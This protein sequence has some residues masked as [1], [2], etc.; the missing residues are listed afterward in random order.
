M[1]TGRA[2]HTAL[3]KPLSDEHRKILKSVE[4]D[5]VRDMDADEIL[6]R[7][8]AENVFNPTEEERIKVKTIRSEKNGQ[9][10][11]ILPTKG[12][13]AYQ[14]FKEALL[15]VH[16]PLRNIIMERENMELGSNANSGQAD[17]TTQAPDSTENEI[18]RKEVVTFQRCMSIQ[19]D[20][21]TC[22]KELGG[23]LQI[24][25][26][27]LHNIK[28]DNGCARDRGLAVLQSWR[29]REGNDATVGCLFDAFVRIGKKRTAEN[30]FAKR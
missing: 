29:D 6:L 25:E 2:S 14:I 13:K 22:W 9:F 1:A 3:D 26:G 4:R 30:Y 15:A 8:A 18:W 27:E 10:L 12:A 20:A 11:E 28:T 21:G 16:P 24:P 19:D 7:M 5:L 17:R 23:V